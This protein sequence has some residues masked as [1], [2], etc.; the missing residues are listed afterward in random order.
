MSRSPRLESLTVLRGF[1]AL[2]VVVFHAVL[3]F[4]PGSPLVHATRALPV[5]VSFFF[6]LS[7]FVLTWS[8]TDDRP[9]AA[10]W[11]DRAARILPVYLFAWLIAVA[12]LLMA[13]V[14]TEPD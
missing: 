3:A 14:A 7:G 4:S 6:V 2:A 13:T 8:W 12:A 10:F 11:R 5:A 1:A 9:L